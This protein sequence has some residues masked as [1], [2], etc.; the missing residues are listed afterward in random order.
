MDVPIGI[1]RK[2][3]ELHSTELCAWGRP[4][5][6]GLFRKPTKY[7]LQPNQPYALHL[8]KLFNRNK[9][10]SQPASGCFPGL[11]T[12]NR[13]RSSEMGTN[14]LFNNAQTF[15]TTHQPKSNVQARMGCAKSASLHPLPRHQ[16]GRAHV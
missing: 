7:S 5:S 4:Y 6:Y 13:L 16:I 15:W 9:T 1:C 10:G 11:G 2:T 12:K 3:S 8:S 14:C